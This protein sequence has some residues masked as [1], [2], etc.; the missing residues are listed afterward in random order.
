MYWGKDFLLL[1]NIVVKCVYL[2]IIMALVTV[3]LIY[4]NSTY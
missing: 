2:F 4:C 1:K 3:T